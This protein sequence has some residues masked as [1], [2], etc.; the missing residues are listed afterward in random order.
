M[1][2]L[3]VVNSGLGDAQSVPRREKTFRKGKSKDLASDG[4]IKHVFINNL[5]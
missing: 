1:I 4:S 3:V 5:T 2:G